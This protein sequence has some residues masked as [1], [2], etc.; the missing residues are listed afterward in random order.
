M[1]IILL[2]YFSGRRGPNLREIWEDNIDHLLKKIRSNIFILPTGKNIYWEI[3][4]SVSR[5]NSKKYV[6]SKIVLYITNILYFIFESDRYVL[7]YPSQILR[8]DIGL[9]RGYY[10]DEGC[11]ETS[12]K[13]QNIKAVRENTMY[14]KSQYIMVITNPEIY[15]R[16]N[17]IPKS[18]FY[19][20]AIIILG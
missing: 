20:S 19:S 17:H 15:W 14:R 9:S 3:L 5:Y 2:F 11:P 18:G 16:Y 12:S 6:I 13:I 1:S 8:R 7:S 10:R 4:S